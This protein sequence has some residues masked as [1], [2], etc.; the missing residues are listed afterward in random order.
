MKLRFAGNVEVGQTASK[1]RIAIGNIGHSPVY[2]TPMKSMA[3]PASPM[4]VAAWAAVSYTH[5]RAHETSAHL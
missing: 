5:L 4:F 2:L 3:T 1:A